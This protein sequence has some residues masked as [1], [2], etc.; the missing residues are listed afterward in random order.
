[1]T[2]ERLID[3]LEALRKK[4]KV[5]DLDIEGLSAELRTRDL[6]NTN[7]INIL[8]KRDEEIERL[9]GQRRTINDDTIQKSK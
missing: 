8:R 2:M 9:K 7:L 3:E 6:A 5:L 1:M 4:V